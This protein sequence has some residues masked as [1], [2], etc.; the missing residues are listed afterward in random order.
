M[1][2]CRCVT[3]TYHYVQVCV[4][5]DVIFTL[6]S[7]LLG[8]VALGVGISIWAMSLSIDP[9]SV[10]STSSSTSCQKSSSCCCTASVL[11][12]SSSASSSE[13]WASGAEATRGGLRGFFVLFSASTKV[14][15]GEF[16]YWCRWIC[17]TKEQRK[18][19]KGEAIV[20]QFAVTC[21]ILRS[22]CLLPMLFVWG[23]ESVCT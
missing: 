14:G 1:Y 7:V 2:V 6:S 21:P 22:S 18:T 13:N 16:T 8:T 3:I 23:W 9:V 11:L 17:T 10:D 20:L 5:S 12:F 19:K 15:S 4:L